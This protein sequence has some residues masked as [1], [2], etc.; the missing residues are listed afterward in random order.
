MSAVRRHTDADPPASLLYGRDQELARVRDLIDHVSDRGGA[1]VIRGEAGIGKSALLSQ[2]ATRAKER[3]LSVLTATG[4]Q[5]E[6]RFAFAGLHQLLR[7][8]LGELGRLP[9][10][11]RRALEMAFGIVDGEA[12]DVFLIALAALGVIADAAVKTPLLLVVEDAQWLDRPSC[13][14]LGFIGRRLDMEP[15]VLLFGVREGVSSPADEVGLPELRL[16]PLDEAAASALLSSRAGD[17]PPDSRARVLREAAGNPLALIELPKALAERDDGRTAPQNPLPLTARLEEAFAA[18]LSDFPAGTRTLLLLASLDDRGDTGDLLQAAELM[19]AYPLGTEAFEPAVAGGLGEI[20]SGRFRFRHPLM[21]SAVQQAATPDER[22]RGHAALAKVLAGQPD[23]SVWHRAAAADRPAE[24]VAA[25]LEEVARR[26]ELRGGG[27]VAIAA[28]EL[29]ASLSDQPQR[30]GQ[31]LVQAAWLAFELGRWD[32]SVRLARQAQQL[33]LDGYER[34]KAA[35]LLEVLGSSWSGSASIRNFLR[36]A[37]DLAAA[38]DR[39]RALQALNMVALRVHWAN[40]DE[41]T[42]QRIVDIAGRVT[43]SRDDPVFLEVLAY[44]DPVHQGREVIDRLTSLA[45]ASITGPN[46]LIAAGGAASA[47]WADDLAL[48]FLREASEG[49]RAAGRLQ[50]LTAALTFEAWAYVRRGDIR[51]AA[52]AAG[53]AARMALELKQ[54]RFL[55][56]AKAVLAITAGERG[57]AAAAGELTA[58]AEASLLPMGANPLLALVE[59][60][61]GRVALAGERFTEAYD[62]IARIFDPGDIVHHPFVRGWALADIVDAA[63]YGEQDL[64]EVRGFI[65]EW[66]PIA[67]QTQAGHLRVQVAYARAVLADEATA[68][69][70]FAAAL[71]EMSGWPSYRA[72]TQ[73][74]YGTWLRRRRHNTESRAPLREAADTFTALG[75]TRLADRA[76]RELRASGETVRQRQPEVW[77]QLTPQELQ[78]AQLAAEG[79]TNREIGER[80]YISHRTV[81]SHLYQ[82]FP[83]LGVT[84]RTELRAVLEPAHNVSRAISYKTNGP[85]S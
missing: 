12:P 4:V 60:A 53:E 69:E 65:D 76:H 58:E 52:P 5:S 23:R 77:D 55:A 62:D 34:T 15:V 29:A 72:R 59:L 8:F 28:L 37:E 78:I 10:P 67:V 22:R 50:Q 80:L 85:P 51:A 35:Y 46:K 14:V 42:R 82:L 75:S 24:T 2:A 33:P 38:G 64:G 47:V 61:R 3:G 45:P 73:L 57:D 26:A 31:R 21:C 17:L 25:D 71:A 40:P 19:L 79:L 54:P 36:V 11:Q 13:E 16:A 68:A 49:F 32:V 74:A 6:A 18:R 56:A 44:A 84:S 83:K 48:P 7:P 9:G 63:I 39:A 66:A 81:G 41:E 20:E 70:R 30:Q 27:D 1:L 43:A